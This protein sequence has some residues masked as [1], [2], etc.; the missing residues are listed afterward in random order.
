MQTIFCTECGS[1]VVYSGSKPKFCS[2]CGSPIGGAQSKNPNTTKNK[3]P[4][5][6]KQAESKESLEPLRDDETDIDSVPNITSLAYELSGEGVGN[7]VYKFEDVL[8]VE[9]EEKQ[10]KKPARKPRRRSSKK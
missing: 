6:R 10:N 2:S 1:K 7:P 8:H 3:T 5:I 4:S 9:Q